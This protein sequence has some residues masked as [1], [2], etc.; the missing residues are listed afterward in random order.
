GT[1]YVNSNVGVPYVPAAPAAT[2]SIYPPNTVIIPPYF[3]NRYGFVEVVTDGSGNLI[4]V[5][6]FTGERIFPLVA[7]FPGGVI[8]PGFIGANFTNGVFL[9]PG[10]TNGIT[11]NG[12]YGCPFGGGFFGNGTFNGPFNG[13]NAFVNCGTLP[14]GATYVGNG[15][16][17]Y[18]DNNACP[19]DGQAAYVVG[20]GYFCRNGDPLFTN[21]GT[22]PVIITPFAAAAPAAPAATTPVAAPVSAAPAAAAPA[23]VPVVVQQPAVAPAPAKTATALAAPVSAAP[24]APVAGSVHVQS[25]TAAPAPAEKETPAERHGG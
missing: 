2:N 19:R 5:N 11:C 7:D 23:A 13:C 10:T 1:A 16:Y 25:A 20:Q 8:G 24:A 22:P 9:P 3:D 18:T 15:T 12:V 4:D 14:A 6:P 17:F 21:G